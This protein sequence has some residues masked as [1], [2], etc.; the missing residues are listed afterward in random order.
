MEK[1]NE[2]RYV[3]AVL[4]KHGRME[5]GVREER[6]VKSRQVLGVY[7]SY[8]RRMCEHWSKRRALSF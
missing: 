8:D 3:G 6:P 4:C 2:F 7:G 1:V 5:G